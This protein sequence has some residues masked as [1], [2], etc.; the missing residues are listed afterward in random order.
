MPTK[1][2]IV[3]GLGSLLVPWGLASF[4]MSFEM[5]AASRGETLINS[6]SR[7]RSAWSEHSIGLPAT[8]WLEALRVSL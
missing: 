4:L 7:K 5:R 3:V 8:Q 1:T 2:E 6:R